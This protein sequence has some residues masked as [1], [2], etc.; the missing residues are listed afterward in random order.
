MEW[1][2]KAYQQMEANQWKG[3]Q[4]TAENIEQAQSLIRTLGRT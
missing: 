1:G 2:Q 4:L 3:H